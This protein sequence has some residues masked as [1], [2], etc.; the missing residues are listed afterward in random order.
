M[1]N[2]SMRIQSESSKRKHPIH[3]HHKHCHLSLLCCDPLR[4]FNH[5]HSFFTV[6][7]LLLI[8]SFI[9][10]RMSSAKELT[11]I[12]RWF[13]HERINYCTLPGEKSRVGRWDKRLV[14]GVTDTL[15]T[16]SKLSIRFGQGGTV[17]DGANAVLPT[18]F[19]QPET[20]RRSMSNNVASNRLG[21][22]LGKTHGVG[23]SHDCVKKTSRVFEQWATQKERTRR[24]RH[25]A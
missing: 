4:F 7:S 12:I 13:V 16:D 24:N 11:Y 10:V 1:I 25:S 19:A 3:Q 17:K 15:C 18:T 14:L 21:A 23:R 2:D 9:R 22:V 6:R 20:S 5:I 8:K